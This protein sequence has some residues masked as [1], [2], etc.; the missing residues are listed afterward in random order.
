MSFAP[1]TEKLVEEDN[2]FT[3]LTTLNFLD[4]V[5]ENLK[6]GESATVDCPICNES[7]SVTVT[8]SMLNGHLWIHC[9]RCD[10]LLIQ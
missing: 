6:W 5:P 2:D 8:R 10:G 7:Q 9:K 3:G 4:V 1:E